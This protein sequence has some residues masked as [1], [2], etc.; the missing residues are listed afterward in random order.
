MKLLIFVGINVGGWAGWSLGEQ[1][2]LL[3]AFLCSGAGSIVG[4]YLSWRAARAI[5]E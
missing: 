4:V 3:T 1:F 2:G 5:L